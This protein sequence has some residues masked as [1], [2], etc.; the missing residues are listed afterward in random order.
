MRE[1]HV[2]VQLKRALWIITFFEV[3]DCAVLF[4]RVPH[5]LT[6][7]ALEVLLVLRLPLRRSCGRGAVR[8]QKL[9]VKLGVLERLPRFEV[10]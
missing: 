10:D 3:V 1:V 9:G 6:H 5:H 2:S 7:Q 4:E 8:L